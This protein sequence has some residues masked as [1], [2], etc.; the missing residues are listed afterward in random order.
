MKKKI[1]IF[2]SK[3]NSK[4][5]IGRLKHTHSIVCAKERASFLDNLGYMALGKTRITFVL[6]KS[7]THILFRL[8][9]RPSDFI[10]RIHKRSEW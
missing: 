8:F 1:L 3:F 6:Q 7:S 4:F 10:N 5:K 2:A 9:S